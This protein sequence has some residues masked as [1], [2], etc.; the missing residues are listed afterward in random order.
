MSIEPLLECGTF[1]VA[2]RW[3]PFDFQRF[4]RK[5]GD[6]GGRRLSGAFRLTFPYPV[7]GPLALGWSSH[8]GMGLFLPEP[9]I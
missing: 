5:C 3:S 1:K 9:T 6:D 2:G 8:F 7:R 4:R